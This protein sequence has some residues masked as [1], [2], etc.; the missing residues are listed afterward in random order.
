MVGLTMRVVATALL[1]L[2]VA[3]HVKLYYEP[4]ELSVRNARGATSDGQFSVNGA[5][6]G[7][8]TYGAN[9][10]AQLVNGATLTV[11][12]NYNGG[13]SSNSNQFKAAYR[14]GAPGDESLMES[15]EFDLGPEDCT[16]GGGCTG[17]YPC[18]AAQ[19]QLNDDAGYQLTCT[20]PKD[21]Q[22][23]TDLAPGESA[24]CTLSILDQRDWGGCIDI[25][26]I[27]PAAAE[28]DDDDEDDD[29]RKG[30]D[31]EQSYSYEA[32]VQPV[33]IG[34]DDDGDAAT[35]EVL[36]SS[37]PGEYEFVES[38]GGGDHNEEECPYCG[39]TSG[40]ATIEYEEDKDRATVDF[41][42]TGVCGSKSLSPGTEFEW[43]GRVKL[44]REDEESK[45]FKG[46]KDF[47]PDDPIEIDEDVLDA[48]SYDY[49]YDVVTAPFEFI[50]GI[51][52]VLTIENIGTGLPEI[53]DLVAVNPD[54]LRR[55]SS[56]GGGGGG[57][58]G[59]EEG[60]PNVAIIIIVL[61]VLIVLCV[62]AY[63][64]T[65]YQE[66]SN[67]AALAQGMP[68]SSGGAKRQSAA[69]SFSKMNFAG[70]GGANTTTQAP[71][72]GAGPWEAVKDESSG[73]TYWWN[74]ATGETTWDQPP[75][76]PAALV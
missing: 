60:G 27:E 13:H 18:G 1:A 8:N 66:Q 64:Y 57:S 54:A 58:G 29:R 72:P 69:L 31:G 38:Y 49:S 61:I 62:L 41:E 46:E 3:C 47:E 76:A 30:D 5:C 10:V 42:F 74:P 14:C 44:T 7:S 59:G 23:G 16:V 26:A 2:P 4:T 45:Q 71:A 53:C 75:G 63:M 6:G 25:Q 73:D 40:A 68:N 24:D 51:D 67:A 39:V 35:P 34:G 43:Q 9:G 17:N 21:A 32:P 28:D 56:G 36:A 55:G 11:K 52:G 37:L 48:L 50:L 33:T 70:G 19:G 15:G 12:I 65:K 20:L 22:R